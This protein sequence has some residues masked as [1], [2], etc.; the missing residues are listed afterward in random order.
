LHSRIKLGLVKERVR[1]AAANL[2]PQLRKFSYPVRQ[3]KN[4]GIVSLKDRRLIRGDMI[5]VY[6]LLMGKEQIDCEQ[7]FR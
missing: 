7:F 4:I 1:K 6:K 5:E 3:T 2:V